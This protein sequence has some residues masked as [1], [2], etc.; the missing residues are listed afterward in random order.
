MTGRVGLIFLAPRLRVSFGCR[1]GCTS[2]RHSSSN[3]FQAMLT[4]LKTPDQRRSPRTARPEFRDV[5]CQ[6]GYRGTDYP[7]L[8]L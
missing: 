5:V 1:C 3:H 7:L 8:V 4:L 6:S 2:I